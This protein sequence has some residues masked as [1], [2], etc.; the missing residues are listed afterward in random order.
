MNTFQLKIVK[1]LKIC[2]ICFGALVGLGVVGLMIFGNLA[3][4]NP[5]DP[6]L[7]QPGDVL[8]D[9]EHMRIY[10][11]HHENERVV[12]ASS[13]EG[14]VVMN[15]WGINRTTRHTIRVYRYCGAN[16]VDRIDDPETIVRSV[17]KNPRFSPVGE[18]QKVVPSK[19]SSSKNNKGK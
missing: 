6:Q 9:G 10:Y 18:Q 12:S 19:K 1:A 2:G 11:S 3:P 16:I 14:K 8:T 4:E 5:L 7:P 17:H 15:D 13:L